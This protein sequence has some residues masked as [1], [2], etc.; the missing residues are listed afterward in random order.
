MII[1]VATT[2]CSFLFLL[3][4]N[5]RYI[6]GNSNNLFSLKRKVS[7]V[8]D[9]WFVEFMP[10]S[11]RNFIEP[12]LIYTTSTKHSVYKDLFYS[13]LVSIVLFI[14]FFISLKSYYLLLAFVIPFIVL[15]DFSFKVESGKKNFINSLDHLVLCLEVLTVKS[16][17]PLPNALSIISNTLPSDFYVACNEINMILQKADKF[18]LEKTL[19]ELH[20]ESVD[21]QEFISILRAIHKGTNKNALK[22]NFNDFVLRQKSI[23]EE[24]RKLFVENMQLYLMLPGTVMLLVAMY[25]LIDMIMFQLQGALI[26]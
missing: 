26:D 9:D 13:L 18:G 17:T 5:S 1:I 14:A 6:L 3:L 20:K 21:E 10:A 11:I 12:N 22:K 15:I 7:I 25:P 19:L 4:L 24:K 8:N 23:Q 16:E 2:L